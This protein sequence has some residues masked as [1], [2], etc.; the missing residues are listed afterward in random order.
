MRCLI[1]LLL[2]TLTQP[3]GAEPLAFESQAKI[4]YLVD[5][6]SGVV[7]FDNNGRKRIPTASMAKMMTAF[8]AFEAIKSKRLD[9][10]QRFAVRPA[11]WKKWNNRGSSMFLKNNEKVSVEDLLHGVL[12]LSGN[13]ASVALAEG[14]SGT[15][16]AFTKEMNAAAKHLKMT[17][18]NFA[19]ANGWPDGGATYSSA[20]DLSTLALAI[21]HLHPDQFKQYFG[22]RSFR[23]NGITQ[24]NRNPLLG[25]IEGADGMKTGH[26]EEAGYC[27]VGTAERNGRRLVMVIAGLPTMEARLREGRALMQWGFDNWEEVPLYQKGQS[28]ATLPTQL[29]SSPALR[30]IIPHRLSFVVAKGTSAE[31]KLSVIY[32]GPIKAPVRKG[33]EIAQL[34]VSYPGGMQKKFPLVAA[35][36]VAAANFFERAWNGLRGLW[37]A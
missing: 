10:A 13:D 8:V 32:S 16:R 1:L 29:G 21:I 18:S 27:L 34:I 36:D 14:I 2:I 26:S 17:N 22:R 35:D 31:P 37:A 7:L 12:T 19:T 25:A 24:P 33:E 30:A 28:V 20:H 15:E 4:A 5:A 3:V 11:I 23:W 6:S 9:P